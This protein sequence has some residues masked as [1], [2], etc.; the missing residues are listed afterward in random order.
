[1]PYCLYLRK[2]RAD[3][4]A[5]AHG[6]GETLARHEKIL[7]DLA[8]KMQLNV[9][10]I[11]KEVV[12]GETI[13]ARPVVQNLLHE[14][15]Q[16]LWEGV[17]VVEVERLAR[18]DTIDQGIVAQTFKYSDT[19]IITPIKTYNPNN[20]FDEEYFEFGL[21][22]SRREYKT[23]N[24]RLQRGRITSAKEGK[25]AG[26][27]A[28]YGYERVKLEHDKG[29]TLKINEDEA[30]IIRLIFEWYTIGIIGPDGT[31]ER[32]G[33]AKI[34]YRLNDIHIPTKKG[35][36]W[37]VPTV[38]DILMNPTYAGLIRWNWRKSVK[39]MID[40]Q[41]VISR[42]RADKSEYLISK[43]LHPAI[44]TSETFQLAQN[45]MSQHLTRPI[46]PKSIVANPLASI[47][48]CGLCGKKMQRRPYSNGRADTLICP[49]TKCKNV[50]SDLNL[51]EARVLS[52]LRQWV[53]NYKLQWDSDYKK[54]FSNSQVEVKKDLLNKSKEDLKALHKQINKIHDLL[55]HG[56]YDIDI[57]LERSK[58]LSEKIS[59][60][61]KNIEVQQKDLK[62]EIE[63]EENTKNVIPKIENLLDVYDEL[64]TAKAK[65]DM[66]KEVLE[67][68]VYLKKSSARWH[69]SPDDF[70]IVI[71]PKVPFK[72]N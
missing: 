23:I 18:G 27:K 9:T 24:R 4:E 12:S 36:M 38:R 22:M 55:E 62:V 43:G 25:F 2:S 57:F 16:G 46:S 56:I 42:P 53:D 32:I 7:L 31:P 14:V 48:V 70:E 40:G 21:F 8:K 65:N 34:A 6:E 30:K 10:A 11:Y 29:W 41:I 26:N 13:A 47:V 68:I 64:P 15:E 44:V 60:T 52:A 71:Y 37:T 28:P 20:E 58:I 63:R 50:S 19:K 69:G 33:T 17:L 54:I 5:E 59:T 39:K 51:V 35:G 49:N 45:I 67:K 61:E 3:T 1:M 66:L 72:N